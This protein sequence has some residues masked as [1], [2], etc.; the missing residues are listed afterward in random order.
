MQEHAFQ[1]ELAHLLVE[2]LIAVLGISRDRV[3]GVRGMHADL[4][5]ST[6]EDRHLEQTRDASERLHRT[7]VAGRLLA[8]RHHLDGAFAADS[9]IGT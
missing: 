9:Q 1:P 8:A 5:R 6:G 2:L 4:V 7:E 3:T